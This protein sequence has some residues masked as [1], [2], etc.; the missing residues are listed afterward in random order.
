MDGTCPAGV[1]VP[2]RFA[3]EKLGLIGNAA[4]FRL[5]D[6]IVEQSGEEALLRL[7]ARAPVHVRSAF[8]LSFALQHSFY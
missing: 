7:G 5:V 8:T 1:T 3:D 4:V 2:I 6:A